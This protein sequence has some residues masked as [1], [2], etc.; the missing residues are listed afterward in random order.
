MLRAIP[1][2][3]VLTALII[4]TGSLVG[5]GYFAAVGIGFASMASPTDWIYFMGLAALPI[6]ALLFYLQSVYAAGLL[7]FQAW[8]KEVR[9]VEAI[10]SALLSGINIAFGFSIWLAVARSLNWQWWVL[11]AL[12][13][14]C[15]LPFQKVSRHYLFG[16]HV[17]TH[18]LAAAGLMM[19]FIPLVL[20]YIWGDSQQGGACKV[21]TKGNR[22]V[23]MGFL[24]SI[25]AGQL[26]RLND[27]T[28][29]LPNEEISQM[30]CGRR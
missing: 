7:M 11:P 16:D 13:F 22:T 28:V 27:R 2:S 1:F 21:Y 5:V 30:D 17:E 19:T 9:F 20:G 24:R 29:W 26:F 10:P 12:I 14:L 25:G 8:K 6:A 4:G 18:H 3:V 15:W 23:A